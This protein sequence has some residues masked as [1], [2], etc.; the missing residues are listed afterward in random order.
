[1]NMTKIKKLVKKYEH[2]TGI[3]A[4]EFRQL[5][6]FTPEAVHAALSTDMTWHVDNTQEMIRS[7]ERAQDL[8]FED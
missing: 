7:L 8:C 3:D 4:Q 2:Q 6:V 5:Q 1:M